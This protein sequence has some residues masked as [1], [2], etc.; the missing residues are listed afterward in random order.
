AGRGTPGHSPAI[1]VE[2]GKGPQVFRGPIETIMLSVPQRSQV[3]TAVS[4][5]NALGRPRSSRRVVE[6]NSVKFVCDVVNIRIVWC[7]FRS[8]SHKVGKGWKLTRWFDPE[9]LVH[10]FDNG[11]WIFHARGRIRNDV[12]D[13]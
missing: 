8:C 13:F 4:V 2:H 11:R 1:A 9:F 10:Q 3:G 12:S 6:G 7:L 5:K